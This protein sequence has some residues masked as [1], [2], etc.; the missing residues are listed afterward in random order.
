MKDRL[1]SIGLPL[2][3]AIVFVTGWHFAV[4]VTGSDIFPTPLMVVAG[5]VE[6]A[7]KGV[8]VKYIVAS[9][10]RVTAG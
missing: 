6:L 4:K 5:L 3:V 9:L 8:L 1:Q 10:F 2:L 7:Q